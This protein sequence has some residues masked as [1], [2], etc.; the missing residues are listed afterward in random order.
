MEVYKPL[1]IDYAKCFSLP[2]DLFA[3]NKFIRRKKTAHFKV[4]MGI[5]GENI[6]TNSIKKILK[7]SKSNKIKLFE[8][9]F[10]ESKEKIYITKFYIIT[11]LS[12]LLI[13]SYKDG[14]Y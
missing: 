10:V 8:K 6:V 7:L 12:P 13:F 1:K 4:S 11:S 5:N 14:I 2:K 9:L 3:F